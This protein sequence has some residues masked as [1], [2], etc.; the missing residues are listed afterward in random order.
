[1]TTQPVDVLVVTALQLERQAVRAHLD[2]IQVETASGLAADLG[3]SST[4]RTQRIVVIE[5]GPGNVA[6][7]LLAVRGE[8][9]FRP[10]YVVMLGVAGGV[11][12][13]AIGDV[14]ASSKVYWIEGGKAAPDLKPRPDFAPVSVALLQVARGV[15]TD[16]AWL[17]RGRGAAGAW[18][19]AGREPA[20]LVGPIVVGEKVIG[21]RASNAAEVIAQTYSDAVAIDMEDFGVLRGGAATER[22]S[23]LAIR[24]ISDLLSE[25]G[26]A[27][28]QG[29]QLLAAANAAAFLFDLLDRLPSAP[30]VA[31]SPTTDDLSAV[32]FQVGREL[33]PEGPQQDGLWERAGGDLSR[34]RLEGPGSTRWWNAI[35]LVTRGGGGSISLDSLIAEMR[36]DYPSNL[37]LHS[38]S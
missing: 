16:G 30:G 38:H 3:V 32:A 13:V 12:D 27:D 22:A 29:S 37:R 6:A 7:S 17:S 24:G 4:R 9:M 11:K 15:A 1:M 19:G 28:A 21:D 31:Q 18:P 25:K 34:L 35:Q 8:E 2:D 20:A 33:Y 23:V 10:R 26:D 36:T 5:T 14:V